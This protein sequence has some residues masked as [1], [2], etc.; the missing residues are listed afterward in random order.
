MRTEQYYLDK[1][2]LMPG[3]FDSLFFAKEWAPAKYIYD[4]ALRIAAFL[5]APEEVRKE[6]FGN[7][8]Y[9]DY[10]KNPR[11]GLFRQEQVQKCYDECIR[12]RMTEE[13]MKYRRLGEQVKFYQEEEKR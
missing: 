12:R 13:N 10:E 6:L 2:M 11:D 9:E 1:L 3:Q 7:Y 5:E 8:G 4:T